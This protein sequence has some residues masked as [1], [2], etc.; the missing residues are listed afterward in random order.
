VALIFG[1]IGADANAAVLCRKRSGRVVIAESCGKKGSPLAAADLG[2]VGQTGSPGA[3]G[4]RGRWARSP[5][6]AVGTT[7]LGSY[8]N[9]F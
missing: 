1:T 3:A 4:A 7:R 5:I 2:L 8:P 6:G 9:R